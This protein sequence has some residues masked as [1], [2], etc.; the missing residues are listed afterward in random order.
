MASPADT[1]LLYPHEVDFSKLSTEY[2]RVPP[3][4]PDM[5]NIVY[6]GTHHGI[7]VQ[8]SD[9]FSLGVSMV[10]MR[11][12][13]SPILMASLQGVDYP[14][15]SHALL[16]EEGANN[17]QLGHVRTYN[18]FV[19][20]AEWYSRQCSTNDHD[21]AFCM[22]VVIKPSKVKRDGSGTTPPAITFKLKCNKERDGFHD[23][24]VKTMDGTSIPNNENAIVSALEPKTRFDAVVIIRAMY[25]SWKHRYSPHNGWSMPLEAK[26]ILLYPRTG[27]PPADNTK[28]GGAASGSSV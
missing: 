1:K 7:A 15:D 2:V 19:K 5:V 8:V 12:K 27:L 9:L 10:D 20:L 16:P 17:A 3:G 14:V 23:L 18:F 26:K 13:L 21:A 22:G 4:A 25:R 24:C 28:E 6:D 11:G